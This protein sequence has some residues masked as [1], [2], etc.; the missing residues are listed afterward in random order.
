MTR[1]AELSSHRSKLNLV[2]CGGAQNGRAGMG[3]GGEG[4]LGRNTIAE[5]KGK[6]GRGILG[7]NTIAE[8]RVKGLV[9]VTP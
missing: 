8:V 3:E 9:V 6:V 1:G 4:I 2:G 5:V 7:R